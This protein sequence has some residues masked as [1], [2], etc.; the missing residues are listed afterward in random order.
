MEPIVALIFALLM[1]FYMN[2]YIAS[3]NWRI[4]YRCFFVYL[5]A[6]IC[7]YFIALPK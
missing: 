7:G 1:G 5:M 3:G 4:F 2:T 6:A